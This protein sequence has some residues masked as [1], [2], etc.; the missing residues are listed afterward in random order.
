MDELS[1]PRPLPV[2]VR[3]GILAVLGIDDIDELRPVARKLCVNER[4]ADALVRVISDM[5]PFEMK[6]LIRTER[7]LGNDI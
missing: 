3:P 1:P 7:G 2:K 4:Q 5:N 6:A